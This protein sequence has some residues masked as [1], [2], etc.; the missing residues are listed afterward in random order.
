MRI[1]PGE[2]YTGGYKELS[3][4]S[5]GLESSLVV[6]SEAMFSPGLTNSHTGTEVGGD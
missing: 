3:S 5:C 2:Q 6:R 1:C 4:T